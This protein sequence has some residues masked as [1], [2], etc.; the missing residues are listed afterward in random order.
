MGARVSASAVK[1]VIETSL[2]DGTIDSSMIDTA[3]LYVDTH[4]VPDAG[5]SDEVLTKIEL[6]LAAH[7]VALTEEKGGITRAKMGDAD[8]SYANVYASGFKSTRYG[9]TAL[10]FDTSGILAR[11]SITEPKA[12]FRVV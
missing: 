2:T 3:N 5:H 8:E 12:E 1:E 9:Q 10:N 4:L 7:F 6:Y 11:L